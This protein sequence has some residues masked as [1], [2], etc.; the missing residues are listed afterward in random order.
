MAITY[1]SVNLSGGGGSDDR[2]VKVSGDDG[3][4]G[5]LEEKIVSGSTKVVVETINPGVNEKVEIDLD[6]TRI[7]H[8]QLL[9]YD[10]DQHRSLDDLSTTTTSLWSSTKIQSEL[11]N[12]VNSVTPVTDNTLIKSVGTT[13]VDFEV[14][15]VV[16]DDSNNVTGINDLIIDGD[17]TVNGTTT[18]VNSTTL[19]I[20]DANITLNNGG[21]QASANSQNAGITI[22]MSDATDALISYNSSN[23]SKFEIGE[24]GDLR[25]VLTSS[26][27]QNITNKTIDLDNNTLI[28]VETDNFKVGVVLT[29]ISGSVDNTKIAGAQS[30]KDYVTTQLATQDEASEITY[31]NSTSGLTATDTQAAIDEVEGRVDVVETNLNNHL[32]TNPAKHDADQIVFNGTST[33]TATDVEAAIEELDSEKLNISDFNSTFDSQLATKTTDNLTEGSTNLYFT[34]ERAQDSVGSILIDSSSIDFTYNDV[35]N[36]ITATVIDSGVN[37]NSLNNYIVNEHINHANVDIIAGEGLTGGGNITADRTL[38]LDITNLTLETL[39]DI[40]NDE[41]LIYDNST[42]SHKKIKINQITST[43][44]GVGDINETTASIVQTA[45]SQ[46]ITGFLFDSLEVR[47]FDAQVVVEIEA[48]TDVYEEFKIRG[49]NKNGTWDYIISSVG[50]DTDIIFN[51]NASGQV[52]YNSGSYTGFVAGRVKFKAKTLTI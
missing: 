30:I 45:T 36:E 48:D 46:N 49:V 16:V 39:V 52:I 1:K 22:E 38:E 25:E 7:D 34:E 29:D 3:I 31:D 27:S 18:S 32:N 51:V 15:G 4:P 43:G 28:N 44:N 19:D 10:I 47:S 21:T 9:N 24:S 35:L 11:D 37:H 42:S 12:K 5:F 41:L 20:V 6:Q 14:T 40:D 13:G 33:L 23:T 50:D 8:N 17:L 2:R 26:H